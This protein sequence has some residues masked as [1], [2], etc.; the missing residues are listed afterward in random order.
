MLLSKIM[1]MIKL[2][3]FIQY[4]NLFV[5]QTP[6]RSADQKNI[7]SDN[8]GISGWQNDDNWMFEQVWEMGSGESN[9][10]DTCH[11]KL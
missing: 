11:Q 6:K 4:T 7:N 3:I 8:K 5:S 2:I 9:Y 1:Q 10:Q